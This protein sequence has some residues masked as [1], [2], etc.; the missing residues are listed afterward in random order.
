M[1]IFFNKRNKKKP[2]EYVINKYIEKF[3]GELYIL[4]N[5]NYDWINI[6][7]IKDY[8]LAKKIF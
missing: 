4:K 7:T 2:W 5:Q 6:N 1:E 3:P 8:N